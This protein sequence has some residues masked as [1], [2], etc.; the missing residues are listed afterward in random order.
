[1]MYNELAMDKAMELSGR[2]TECLIILCK[3][4][5]FVSGLE[6][7]FLQKLEN[8]G[9]DDTEIVTLFNTCNNDISTL[10]QNLLS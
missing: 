8:L 6:V 5:K 2:N 1:M 3:L 4:I 9:L 10:A 7:F